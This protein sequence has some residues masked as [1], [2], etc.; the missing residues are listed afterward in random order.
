[1]K[2][3]CFVC[4]HTGNYICGIRESIYVGTFT[5]TYI[6]IRKIVGLHESIRRDFENILGKSSSVRLITFIYLSCICCI[7][8]TEINFSMRYM[9]NQ[10]VSESQLETRHVSLSTE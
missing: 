10:L 4:I 8:L 2:H 3:F 1:M 7:N 6:R 9:K 5:P